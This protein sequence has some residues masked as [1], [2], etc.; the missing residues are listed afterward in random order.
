M[1]TSFCT[2][3]FFGGPSDGL[4]LRG[5]GFTVRDKLDL[6]SCPAFKR[7]RQTSCYEL[8]GQWSTAYGLTSKLRKLEAG[9]PTTYLRYDF[10]GY[11]LTKTHAD[12][13]SAGPVASRWLACVR[14]AL[15]RC[16]HSFASWMLEPVDYPLK[17]AHEQSISSRP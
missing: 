10:L 1:K 5:P 12:R 17:V 9:H 4:I 7:H 11:E 3:Q 2:I 13:S 15:S 14:N 8:V 6:P 16:V